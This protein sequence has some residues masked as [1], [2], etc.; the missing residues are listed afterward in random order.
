M[1]DL[2][3]GERRAGLRPAGTRY[4]EL[5][6]CPKF[7]SAATSGSPCPG[8]NLFLFRP[9]AILAA[10]VATLGEAHDLGWRLSVYCRWGKRDGMKSIRECQARLDADL[11]RWC[12]R[13]GATI[14]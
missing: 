13:A 3:R 7:G 2:R 8:R 14:R 11:Q 9:Y 12:G 6:T 4:A 10:M 5:L 1:L